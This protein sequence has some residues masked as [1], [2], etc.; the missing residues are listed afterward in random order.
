MHLVL[1]IHTNVSV[2]VT[3]KESYTII[4][5]SLMCVFLHFYKINKHRKENIKDKHK[6]ENINIKYICV[7]MCILCLYF[8]MFIH[9]IISIFILYRNL[10]KYASRILL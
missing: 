9:N 1:N 3:P 5:I 8:F 2:H 7:C 6:K 4:Y 10:E